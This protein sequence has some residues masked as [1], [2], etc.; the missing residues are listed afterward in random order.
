MPIEE[1]NRAHVD[2]E[3]LWLFA[4]ELTAKELQSRA[5]QIIS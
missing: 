1:K 5:V 3:T 4:S 2:K